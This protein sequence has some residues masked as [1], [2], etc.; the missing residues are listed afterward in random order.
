MTMQGERLGTD[1]P[2]VPYDRPVDSL[3]GQ[4]ERARDARELK[5]GPDQDA[6]EKGVALHIAALV[7]RLMD[8]TENQVL[9]QQEELTNEPSD[10]VSLNLKRYAR[11]LEPSYA[12][13][14]DG[15]YQNPSPGA[16]KDVWVEYDA[17][18]HTDMPRI[19][20][21]ETDARGR[22]PSRVSTQEAAETAA[23]LL[24]EYRGGLAEEDTNASFG[25]SKKGFSQTAAIEK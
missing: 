12:G 3:E 17:R 6:R 1:F 13:K 22:K 7:D 18:N 24:A 4:R 21:L 20:G 19:Q 8:R 10:G 11:G 23:R 14:I 2:I 16:S 15:H 5:R 9:G 25:V